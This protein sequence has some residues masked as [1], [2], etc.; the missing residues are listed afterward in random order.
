VA[1]NDHSWFI[2]CTDSAGRPRT[3]D[4]IAIPGRPGEV[5]V[6]APPGESAI[7]QLAV[8]DELREALLDAMVK[9]TRSS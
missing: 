4:V 9:A 8:I 2:A 1:E 3:L 7:L 5:I 6:K